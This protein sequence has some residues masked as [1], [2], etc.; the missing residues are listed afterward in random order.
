MTSAREASPF[1]AGT[2]ELSVSVNVEFAI[3]G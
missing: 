3:A 1:E 2:Q